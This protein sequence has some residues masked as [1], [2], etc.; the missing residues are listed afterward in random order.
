MFSPVYPLPP[1]SCKDSRLASS[2]AR[3]WR[4]CCSCLSSSERSVLLSTSSLPPFLR[5]AAKPPPPPH[6]LFLP[7][8]GKRAAPSTAH[9]RS[10]RPAPF[11]SPLAEALHVTCHV[12][13]E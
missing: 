12:P 1:P 8:T 13:E 6:S 9:S 5:P 7:P 10:A 2:S 4:R 3:Q 11:A